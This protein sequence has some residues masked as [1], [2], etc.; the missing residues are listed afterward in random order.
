MEKYKDLLLDD[1]DLFSEVLDRF[2]PMGVEAFK[3]SWN[4]EILILQNNPPATASYIYN[5][6]TQAVYLLGEEGLV[7][8]ELYKNNPDLAKQA[9][10]DIKKFVESFVKEK[11]GHVLDNNAIALA[12]T[13]RT[14]AENENLLPQMPKFF[15][16]KN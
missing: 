3:R 5:V 15:E 14:F 13:I 11:A 9:Q 7:N 8:Y 10:E 16:D 2:S 1:V 4:L 6:L 12:E